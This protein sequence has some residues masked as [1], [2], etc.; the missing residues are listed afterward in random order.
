M[1]VQ[2]ILWISS[3]MPSIMCIQWMW[4]SYPWSC[5]LKMKWEQMWERWQWWWPIYWSGV[6]MS[7]MHD[8]FHL[9]IL[10]PDDGDNTFATKANAVKHAHAHAHTIISA[11]MEM[12]LLCVHRFGLNSLRSF[13]AFN[14]ARFSWAVA[15]VAVTSSDRYYYCPSLP[16]CVNMAYWITSARLN[17][18]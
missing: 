9:P 10:M 1:R 15:A 8:V 16:L 3:T 4:T 7:S 14:L 2:M 11:N 13:Q 5:L 17:G 18:V 6:L 12:P